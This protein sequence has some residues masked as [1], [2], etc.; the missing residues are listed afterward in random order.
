MSLLILII[1]FLLPLVGNCSGTLVNSFLYGHWKLDKI[2]DLGTKSDGD[3]PS[4]NEMKQELIIS[5]SF[6]NC[7]QDTCFLIKGSYKKV[8]YFIS[9]K[10]YVLN[11]QGKT[12][13]TENL[14]KGTLAYY[15][16]EEAFEDRSEIVVVE[17]D[18]EN[19]CTFEISKNGDLAFYCND[20]FVLF[21]KEDK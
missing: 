21:K 6:F 5:K 20:E 7:P 16:V 19:V 15:G 4:E 12:D 2:V 14:D 3:R 1:C 18:H 8:K 17:S 9:T 13:S 10:W 11:S